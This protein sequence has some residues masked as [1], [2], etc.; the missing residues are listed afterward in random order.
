MS[1]NGDDNGRDNRRWPRLPVQ[2]SAEVRIEGV[3]QLGVVNDLPV[4][5]TSMKLTPG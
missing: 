1:D 5:G 3:P 2:D 4:E